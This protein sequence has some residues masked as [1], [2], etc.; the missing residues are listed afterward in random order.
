MTMT[1]PP[2]PDYRERLGALIERWEAQPQLIVPCSDGPRA[3]EVG[4]WIRKLLNGDREMREGRKTITRLKNAV[5]SMSNS[6]AKGRLPQPPD[7]DRRLLIAGLQQG[8]TRL[9][10]ELAKSEREVRDTALDRDR[11]KRRAQ[12][13]EAAIKSAGINKSKHYQ[14]NTTPHHGDRANEI[15]I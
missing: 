15:G 5:E 10:I 4:A 13:A 8:C 7:D 12:E 6:L 14:H 1:G 9:S 2:D 3:G 11:W